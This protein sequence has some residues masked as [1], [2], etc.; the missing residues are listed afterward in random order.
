MLLIDWLFGRHH[1]Y[2]TYTIQTVN[3]YSINGRIF[4]VD[5]RKLKEL[6]LSEFRRII[7]KEYN[8][9]KCVITNIV[10]LGKYLTED[11]VSE[12]N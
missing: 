7:T 9:L 4:N 6:H 11:Y 8:D 12:T 1:F 3:G 2:V 5:T 10:Y